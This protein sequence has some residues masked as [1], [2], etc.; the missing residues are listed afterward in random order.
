[1]AGSGTGVRGEST[2]GI[3]VYGISTNS[4]GCGGS[5]FKAGYAGLFGTGNVPG[6]T[7][8]Y[9]AGVAGAS[10]GF[11][12]GAVTVRGAFQVVGGPKN[13]LVPHPDGSHRRMYCQESP[14]PWFEDFGT[15][16][17]KNGQA[18]VTLDPEFDAVVRGDDY[19]VFLTEIGDC[20]GLY[21]S[22]KGPHRFEVR[23]RGGAAAAGTFDYR[24]VS[25]RKEE[26]G[27][28]MEKVDV[29]KPPKVDLERLT[30]PG[31]DAPSK[32]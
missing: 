14:E 21:V 25:R 13:A 16:A 4:H 24:V 26:V 11:F 19:R 15:A 8:F 10:A 23:S 29:P 3:G 1:V 30:R 28:R 31:G 2:D 5:T 22:Q 18:A 17:L 32:P 27:K 9:A 7:G 20:G 12:E 6:S